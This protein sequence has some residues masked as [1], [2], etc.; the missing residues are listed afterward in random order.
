MTYWE[1]ALKCADFFGHRHQTSTV[2]N[3]R[4]QGGNRAAVREEQQT[5]YLALEPARGLDLR[6]RWVPLWCW[7]WLK[8]LSVCHSVELTG[9]L[10]KLYLHSKH[11][12][13]TYF[14][15]V[16]HRV[17]TCPFF[18]VYLWLKLVTQKL[19]QQ[20]LKCP[21]YVKLWFWYVHSALCWT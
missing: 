16:T 8:T 6:C 10:L 20:L 17:Q 5:G 13:K 18:S 7:P 3:Q 11:T 12:L 2:S 9:N 1:G 4:W 15:Y 14:W 19:R 21:F